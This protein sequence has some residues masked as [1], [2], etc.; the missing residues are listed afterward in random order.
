MIN[1]KNLLKLMSFFVKNLLKTL[2]AEN[3]GIK[4]RMFTAIQRSDLKGWK[5]NEEHELS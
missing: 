1:Q 5:I 2:N 3:P 4:D